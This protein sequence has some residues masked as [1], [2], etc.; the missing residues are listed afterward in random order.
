LWRKIKLIEKQYLLLCNN[1]FEVKDSKFS[2]G[3]RF[4]IIFKCPESLFGKC[5]NLHFL[6]KHFLHIHAL[7][8]SRL[9]ASELPESGSCFVLC[10]RLELNGRCVYSWQ[11]F[12]KLKWRGN[13][14][15][16]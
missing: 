4:Q 13:F 9:A 3:I 15:I 16:N 8:E 7:A 6:L 14:G 10:I 2:Y 5:G 1:I 12:K 11:S